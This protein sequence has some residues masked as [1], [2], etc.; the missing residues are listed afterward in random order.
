MARDLREAR[1]VA[2]QG[3]LEVGRAPT[4]VAH[5]VPGVRAAQVPRR[6]ELRAGALAGGEDEHVASSMLRL[7][8][9]FIRRHRL[10]RLL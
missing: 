1:R 9:H 6:A 3:R 4:A 5:L 7:A 2:P 8:A 10:A